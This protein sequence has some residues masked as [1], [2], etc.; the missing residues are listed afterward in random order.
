M[1][2]RSKI[3]LAAL[4]ALSLLPTAALAQDAAVAAAE[5]EARQ[6]E[7]RLGG[8]NGKLGGV[9]REQIAQQL[10]EI[11]RLEARLR[12]GERVDPSEIDRILGRI[13]LR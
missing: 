7:A 8:G 1:A 2:R 11:E 9:E 6:L 12:A 5:R 4:V 13:P 10:R 3:A